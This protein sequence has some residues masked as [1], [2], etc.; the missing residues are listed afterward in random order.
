MFDFTDYDRR[1][2][3]YGKVKKGWHKAQIYTAGMK[4]GTSKKGK[5]YQY[6]SIDFLIIEEDVLVPFFTFYNEGQKK[7]DPVFGKMVVIAGISGDYS[8]N[9]GGFF[10]ALAGKELKVYVEHRYKKPNRTR[11]DI[12]TDFDYL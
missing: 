7:P 2:K 6:I 5:P 9:R 1:E 8:N 4:N 3:F 10:K 12:V 11:K